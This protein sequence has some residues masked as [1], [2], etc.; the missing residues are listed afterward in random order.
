M[1]FMAVQ[2]VFTTAIRIMPVLG[3]AVR[4][5]KLGKVFDLDAKRTATFN[6]QFVIVEMLK[7]RR[8]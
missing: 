1:G 2:A 4:L 6:C 3:E 5:P 8:W 7:R